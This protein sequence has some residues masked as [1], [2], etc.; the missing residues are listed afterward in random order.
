MGE[1]GRSHAQAAVGA[2]PVLAALAANG[3]AADA[4]ESIS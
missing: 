1:A 4:A 3:I 2:G